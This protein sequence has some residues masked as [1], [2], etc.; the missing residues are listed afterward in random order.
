MKYSLYC[1]NNDKYY[2]DGKWVEDGDEAYVYSTWNVSKLLSVYKA[3][4]DANLVL[5]PI[6]ED[7]EW[8]FDFTRAIPIAEWTRR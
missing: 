6:I 8:T 3:I 5:V 2:S 4:D 1:L 7:D